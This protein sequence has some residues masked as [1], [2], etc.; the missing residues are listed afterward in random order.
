MRVLRRIAAVLGALLGLVVLAAAGGG[1]WL[2]GDAGQRWLLDQLLGLGQPHAGSLAIG[3]LS[4]DLTSHL[5]IEAVVL[6]DAAGKELVGIDVIDADFSLRAILKKTLRVSRLRVEGL[7]A[8]V[9]Q[10]DAGVDLA[11]L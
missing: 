2:R 10:T 7:R 8:D 9:T 3:S 4:T 5:R 11:Q 6:R 1:L